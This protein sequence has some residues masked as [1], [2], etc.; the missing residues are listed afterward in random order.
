MR[1]QT[2]EHGYT[3]D[4]DIT[5]KEVAVD[6]RNGHQQ[7]TLQN[8]QHNIKCQKAVGKLCRPAGMENRF[9]IPR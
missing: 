8:Y 1:S 7:E 2:D 4:A 9:Q 3:A 5:S 6:L